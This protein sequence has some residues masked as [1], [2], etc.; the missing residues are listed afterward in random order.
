MFY[1][2][3]IKTEI[4][5]NKLNF[6]VHPYLV[7]RAASGRHIIHRAYAELIGITV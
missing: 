5:Q 6:S 3:N 2:K 7:R 4:L 1:F